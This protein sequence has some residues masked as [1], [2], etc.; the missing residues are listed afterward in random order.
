VKATARPMPP[1]RRG[2]SGFSLMNVLVAIVV[3]GLGVFAM[4]RAMIGVRFASTQN[5][6]VSSIATLSNSFWSI[7]QWTKTATATNTFPGSYDLTQASVI[8]SA[9]APLQPWLTQ[10]AAA[11]PNGLAVIGVNDKA[12]TTDCQFTLTLSWQQVAMPGQPPAQ[13]RTQTF[14][15]ALN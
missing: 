13:T 11:L 3:L 7:T 2:A 8:S 10:A 5:E 12:C 1:R 14:Y 9:P 4:M 15:Y 6:A